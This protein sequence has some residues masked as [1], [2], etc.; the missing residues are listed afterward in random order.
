MFDA[1]REMSVHAS[2]L[3]AF[4]ERQAPVLHWTRAWGCPAPGY[5]VTGQLSQGSQRQCVQHA[6]HMPMIFACVPRRVAEGGGGGESRPQA[7]LVLARPHQPAR[8]HEQA[9]NGLL[10]A[11]T[12]PGHWQANNLEV[13]SCP[14]GLECG[15]FLVRA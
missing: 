6:L 7:R 11:L 5:T 13:L 2:S 4:I 9:D 12:R 8:L 10:C 3:R 14:R 15:G 1:A